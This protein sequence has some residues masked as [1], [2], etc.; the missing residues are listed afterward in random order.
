MLNMCFRVHASSTDRTQTA[1]ARYLFGYQF[2]SRLRP[3]ER[4]DDECT[5]TNTHSVSDRSFEY[6]RHKRHN[7][8]F[9]ALWHARTL[10]A[11]QSRLA[12]CRRR[13]RIALCARAGALRDASRQP[14]RFPS[15]ALRCGDGQTRR[16]AKLLSYHSRNVALLFSGVLCDV[17]IN[18][19]PK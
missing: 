17:K 7:L 11:Q 6:H 4:H 14:S 5:N 13:A 8:V 3:L 10:L 1:R 9:D 19:C 2:E 16:R 18:K 15:N 12:P